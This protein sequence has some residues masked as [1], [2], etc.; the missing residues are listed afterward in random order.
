[1]LEADRRLL[2]QSIA[3][4]V[5]ALER[6]RDSVTGDPGA[7][8]GSA[9]RLGRHSDEV[10]DVLLTLRS[11]GTVAMR[12]WDGP[13][14]TEFATVHKELT[15][16]L[17]EAVR[18]LR[19]EKTWLHRCG[20]ALV[21]SRAGMERVIAE[22][23]ANVERLRAEL[24]Q[25]DG[26]GAVFVKLRYYLDNAL[27]QAQ[28]IIR[29][30]VSVFAEG[31]GDPPTATVWSIGKGVVG[32]GRWVLEEMG[33]LPPA[34][35]EKPK[36][37]FPPVVGLTTG[38]EFSESV[39]YIAYR[40]NTDAR[41]KE[42]EELRRL[43]GSTEGEARTLM[44][45]KW[46]QNFNYGGAWDTKPAF[47]EMWGMSARNDFTTPVPNELGTINGRQA[48]MP[49]DLVG[50]IH[51]GYMAA[52]MPRFS[53]V[54]EVGANV[55]DV[56]QQNGTDPGDQLAVRIGVELHAQYPPGQLRPEHVSA[57]IQRHWD[58]FVRIG[59]VHVR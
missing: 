29:E 21:T 6:I 51:Y 31:R 11:A 45:W 41:S 17:S 39:D 24:N 10:Q 53:L 36:T 25:P 7:L 27:R 15:K 26:Q 48:A 16:A 12:Q 3:G 56:L 35:P 43:W 22:Y 55:F 23:R 20:N 33:A 57:A 58:E 5:A 46:G 50:N 18:Q 34:A 1:M 47:N 32:F 14:A 2:D 9:D 13:A 44:L 37:T 49:F 40:M 4:T 54:G 28:Q 8:A 59:K 30:L 19:R 42:A 38:T 52:S